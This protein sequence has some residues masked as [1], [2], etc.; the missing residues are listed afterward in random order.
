M[1]SGAGEAAQCLEVQPSRTVQV[2]ALAGYQDPS[3]IARQLLRVKDACSSGVRMWTPAVSMKYPG[4]GV[5]AFG[6][7]A[8]TNGHIG[9]GDIDSSGA[10]KTRW[11]VFAHVYSTE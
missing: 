11:P 8:P 2:K 5:V 7:Q 1:E 4:A 6:A 10:R 3:C 9:D